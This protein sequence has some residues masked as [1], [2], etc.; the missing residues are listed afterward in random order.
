MLKGKNNKRR[1]PLMPL[2]KDTT[3]I[4]VNHLNSPS[5]QVGTQRAAAKEK[6]NS[7]EEMISGDIKVEEGEGDISNDILADGNTVEGIKHLFP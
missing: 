5:I 2:T 1:V 6:G 7:G 4:Q 3:M